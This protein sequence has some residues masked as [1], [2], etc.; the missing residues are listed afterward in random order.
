MRPSEGI[1][2]NLPVNSLYYRN[3]VESQDKIM[4]NGDADESRV[5]GVEEPRCLREL[6]LYAARVGR[7]AYH[8]VN[9]LNKAEDQKDSYNQ[10]NETTHHQ[11]YS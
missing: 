8:T 6:E 2:V 1:D 11:L 5:Q 7:L 9:T 10:R 4:P 3:V